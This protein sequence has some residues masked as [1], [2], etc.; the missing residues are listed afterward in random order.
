[1]ADLNQM[2]G[3][4]L[5]GPGTVH[6]H[7]VHA[8]HLLTRHHDRGDA[9]PLG[10]FHQGQDRLGCVSLRV[11]HQ[12]VHAAGDERLQQLNFVRRGRIAPAEQR[13]V[14]ARERSLLER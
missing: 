5:N 9:Q 7:R 12:T 6:H 11:E 8:S 14:A 3:R 1:M 13:R 4:K 2:L 10:R